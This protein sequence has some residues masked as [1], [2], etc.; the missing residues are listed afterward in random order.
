MTV[1]T[2]TESLHFEE[3]GGVYDTAPSLVYLCE[4]LAS[5]PRQVNSPD[6]PTPT[7][8][9][10]QPALCH[11][12]ASEF[13]ASAAPDLSEDGV[14][15]EGIGTSGSTRSSSLHRLATAKTVIHRQANHTSRLCNSCVHWRSNVA[16]W[17]RGHWMLT[18]S[19]NRLI[20]ASARSSG[21]KDSARVGSRSGEVMCAPSQAS[22]HCR[23]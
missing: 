9:Y 23:W 7:S 4:E 22:S 12:V 3:T 6:I 1:R 17:R 14:S 2:Y 10:L 21:G 8:K 11:F 13:A 19:K 5:Q 18:C 15:S 16:R 20:S